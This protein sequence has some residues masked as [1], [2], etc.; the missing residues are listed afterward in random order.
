MTWFKD[1]NK[2]SLTFYKKAF[3]NDVWKVYWKLPGMEHLW[4]FI[5]CQLF[6]LSHKMNERTF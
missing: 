6:F 2:K 4:E 3:E 5:H 1:I